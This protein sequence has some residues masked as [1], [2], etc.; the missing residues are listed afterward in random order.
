[1]SPTSDGRR[2]GRLTA[3]R[4]LALLALALVC[5]APPAAADVITMQDV[6]RQDAQK[7]AQQAADRVR[8]R[9]VERIAA[10]VTSGVECVEIPPELPVKE[11]TT[12]VGVATVITT[13]V[14]VLK[15]DPTPEPPGPPE[16]PSQPIPEPASVALLAAALGYV[17]LRR[18]KRTSARA[19]E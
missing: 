8:E 5:R 9:V 7:G 2:P 6:L 13:A 19:G 4:G 10:G 3:A 16:T 14:L 1:M 17:G 12:G 15:A 18:R 11:V